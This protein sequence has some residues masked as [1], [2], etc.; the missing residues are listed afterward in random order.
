MPTA[1]ML[2]RD[3]ILVDACFSERKI[4]LAALIWKIIFSS[5]DKVA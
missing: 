1:L 5:A 3:S 4:R 2:S